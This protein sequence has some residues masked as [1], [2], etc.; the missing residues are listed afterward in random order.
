MLA[1]GPAVGEQL[2]LGIVHVVL[3]PAPCISMWVGSL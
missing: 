2:Q 1:G 3:A